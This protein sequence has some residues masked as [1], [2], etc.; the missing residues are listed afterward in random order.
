MS[1]LLYQLLEVTGMVSPRGRWPGQSRIQGAITGAAAQG[2]Q[3]PL[4]WPGQR[5][6]SAHRGAARH[7]TSLWSRLVSSL[8]ARREG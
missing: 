7:G 6:L 3:R 5:G 4:R 8:S 1:R 2:P